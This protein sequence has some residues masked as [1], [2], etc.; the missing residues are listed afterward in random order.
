MPNISL[1]LKHD[2]LVTG[3]KDHLLDQ[4]LYAI[5]HATEIEIAV[6]FIQP[7][8]L[9][10]LLPAINEALERQ[11]ARGYPLK[12][13]ILTSDYLH[14]TN[15][16]ALRSL[17]QL[18]GNNV[19][20]KIFQAGN[21]SFHIKSYIFVRTNEN[22]S[23]YQGSAFIG[24]NNMSKSAL[25]HAHE[26]CLR[27]DHKPPTDSEQAKQFALI[28]EK[29]AGIFNHKS[30]I[31]LTDQWIDNYIKIRKKP[32]LHAVSEVGD[33]EVEPFTPNCAQEEALQALSNSRMEMNT[34]GLVV[35]GTGMGKTWLA[36]FDAK[37]M[38]AK[39]ILFVAHREEI[40]TQALNTFA[41]LWPEKSSGYYHGKSKERN[42]EM[43]FASVQTLG[44]AAHLNQFK[45]EHFDYIVIDEFHHAS[46][47]TYLNIINYFTPKF[48]L[49]LTATPERTD[50][51]NIL[52]L[53]HDNLVFDRNLVHGIDEKILAPFH[54]HGIWDEFV[55]YEEIPWRNGKF[56]PDELDAQFATQKRAQHIFKHWELHQQS[57]TLA[58]CV[59]KKH[60]DFM[61]VA[62]NKTFS[63]KGFR[64]VAVYSGSK[65]LRNEALTQL[66]RGEI[67]VIFSIDLFN[68]GTDLP[69]IDT[70]LMLRPTESNII[71]LQQL[72]RGLRLHPNKKHLA[73][74][75]FIGN[76]RSFLNKHEILGISLS[77]KLTDLSKV[78][79]AA[80][81]LGDGCYLN[82]DLQVTDFWQTLARQYRKTAL[83]DYI[84]L[85]AHLGHRPSA[86][87]Y[88]HSEVDPQLSKATKQHGSWL[89][90]VAQQTNDPL[91]TEVVTAYHDFL[92]YAVQQTK[93][94]KSFKAIL[95]EAFLE[96]DGFRT[97]P[98][99]ERLCEK[100]WHVL[101]GY[102]FLHKLEL[103][104]AERSLHS[105]HKEWFSYWKKNP[106]HHSI[107][108]DQKTN[109]SWFTNDNGLF[110]ANFTI[111]DRHVDVLADLV[112]ELVDYKLA[113]HVDNKKQKITPLEQ[114]DQD[115]L[116]SLPYYPDLKIACGHFKTGNTEDCEHIEVSEYNVDASKHFLARASGNSMNGG[117][118]PI[119]DGDLLLLEFVSSNSAGSIT[120][121]T[122]AIEML[123][124]SGDNQY[125]LRVIEKRGS[126]DYWLKANNPDYK[127]IPAND[128]MKT[129]ARL[130][131]VMKG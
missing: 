88:F 26:W 12:L 9:D 68:E 122:M 115:N 72:G 3:D 113:K 83:E 131:K 48:M 1:T 118:N 69:S 112:K 39:K 52:S 13:K 22:E 99:V 27:Y 87:E 66:D 57:R 85:E 121:N 21:H 84:N 65:T 50:Q 114:P 7:S 78:S 127:T 8:G 81:Q 120:G 107:K 43:M 51:A 61:S 77:G 25:T 89:N 79:G 49:G 110:R 108:A 19:E 62:F 126:S 14:I 5:N 119:L 104:E 23:F 38:N 80:P 93:M 30:A 42:K 95:L 54:Y 63:K 11:E 29:F 97:P 36:A 28:R 70:V 92:L 74:L 116:I 129:L 31:A 64:S 100:S 94:T 34:R 58:F 123:D 117:K 82:I 6:S 103:P 55:N 60:A 73:V 41:K 35:L 16:I 40:L 47:K 10:L 90:L 4:L 46:A 75:D 67:Q 32:T 91:M 45:P 102:P 18:E 15:P 124:E 109:I 44:K 71:F 33:L 56:A 98:S 24:S 105:T 128:S 53:C 2:V 130:K 111:Q 101:S 125:L 20:V 17:M 37:Q 76:H 59:S 96:L 106:V 86:A